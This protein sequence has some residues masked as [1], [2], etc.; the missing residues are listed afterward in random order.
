MVKI[1]YL[2]EFPMLASINATVTI[3]NF[4][5]IN[6]LLLIYLVK[7]FRYVEMISYFGAGFTVFIKNIYDV[8]SA[9]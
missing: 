4:F 1:K 9:I 6:E 2:P 8:I 7:I 3:D 5:I